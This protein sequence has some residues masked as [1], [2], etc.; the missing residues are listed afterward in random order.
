ML[1]GINMAAILNYKVGIMRS[2]KVGPCRWITLGME[3][4]TDGVSQVALFF[5]DKT[6]SQLGFL[7][8]HTGSL[9]A[10][11]PAADFDGIYKILNTEKPVFVH[12]RLD[13]DE[14]RLISID[15][16]TQEEPLG[17]GFPDKSP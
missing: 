3:N 16:S 13:P 17:E 9:H 6:P 11:L 14:H 7:N 15:V 12:W 1:R 10:D 4:P 8:R 2:A 5:H